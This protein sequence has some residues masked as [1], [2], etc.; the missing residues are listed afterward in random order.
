MLGFL[1]SYVLGVFFS[2]REMAALITILATLATALVVAL[3]PES[4]AW[5]MQRSTRDAAAKALRTLRT[6]DSPIDAILDT[7]GRERHSACEGGTVWGPLLRAYRPLLVGVGLAVV[8]Q[9]CA[10]LAGGGMGGAWAKMHWKG[11]EHTPPP[12]GRAAY[13]SLMASAVFNGIC[14]RQ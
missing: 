3:V 13:V 14:N 2:W 9:V 11:G 7:M 6:P 1:C 5:C 12:P 10:V 8:Q 4:P